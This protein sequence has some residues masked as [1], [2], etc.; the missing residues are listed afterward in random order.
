[1][2]LTRLMMNSVALYAGLTEETGVDVGWHPVGSLRLASSRERME[3]L[4]RQ[5]GWATSFGL[6]LELVS[7]KEAHR[8]FPLMAREGVL[9]AAFL[10]TDGYLDPSGLTLALAEGARRGGARICE[11]VRVTRIGVDRGAVH[12]VDTERGSIGAEVVGNAGR[13]YAPETAPVAAPP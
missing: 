9:G 6:P 13:R 8:R 4:E 2:P 11:G 12:R 3:E 10:P 7:A 5:A 1:M